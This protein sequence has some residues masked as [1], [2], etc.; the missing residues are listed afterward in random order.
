MICW[1]NQLL[2]HISCFYTIGTRSCW[3]TLQSKM[4]QKHLLHCLACSF[5][6]VQA[7]SPYCGDY[8]GLPH[9]TCQCGCY[10]W[11]QIQC[12][13]HLHLIDCYQYASGLSI[14]FQH[15]PQLTEC[16]CS[17]HFNSDIFGVCHLPGN[18]LC[19]KGKSC[20]NFVKC[21]YEGNHTYK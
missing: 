4:W 17:G 8:P 19:S 2:L 1:V 3:D 11:L 15:T 7:I 10:Q 9:P 5:C 20:L 18:Y 13:H 6:G 16:L 21:S 14:H 12:C